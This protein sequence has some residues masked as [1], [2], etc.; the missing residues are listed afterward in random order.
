[1][2][3]RSGGYLIAKIHQIS[4]R[5]FARKLKEHNIDEINPAQ[6][7]ILFA[8]WKDD[9]VPIVQLARE[10]MLEKST[11]TSM[12]DRLEESGYIERIHSREDRRQILIRRTEKDK[13]LQQVY[14]SVSEEMTRLFY[15]GFMVSEIDILEN[16]LDRILENL[17]QADE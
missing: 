11:L 14:T 6:G 16:A 3:L 7:R 4:G 12:L 9:N 5:I 2:S 17:V 1:M 10:T 13:Q 8:L 15:K